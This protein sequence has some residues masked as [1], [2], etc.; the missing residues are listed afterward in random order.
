MI[1]KEFELHLERKQ[2]VSSETVNVFSR[3]DLQEA[4]QAGFDFEEASFDRW[5]KN[6]FENGIRQD[7]RNGVRSPKKF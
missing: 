6:K 2:N 5:F 1:D 7:N 3:N 4:Y